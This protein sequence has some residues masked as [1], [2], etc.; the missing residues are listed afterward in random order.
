MHLNPHWAWSKLESVF[1]FLS[2]SFF[3][4][5]S[6]NI[7]ILIYT[8]VLFFKTSFFFPLHHFCGKCSNF[9][10]RRHSTCHCGAL[11][12]R[13]DTKAFTRTVLMTGL[14]PNPLE[15]IVIFL[16]SSAAI[17]LISYKGSCVTCREL[18]VTA[19]RRFC[20]SVV[21]RAQCCTAGGR[22]FWSVIFACGGR[23]ISLVNNKSQSS[24]K[25]V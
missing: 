2:A 6:R 1:N 7:C 25:H 22:L 4:S 19:L 20:S 17:P 8:V 11:G 12:T 23:T 3:L 10:S 21:V 14:L 5:L 13:S 16:R 15:L 24:T 18:A 9:I